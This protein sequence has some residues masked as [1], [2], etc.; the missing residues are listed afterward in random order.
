MPEIPILSD[1]TL[2]GVITF[3]LL[4]TAVDVIGAYLLAASQGKFDLSY[5]AGWLTSHT[6]KRVFPIYAL[7]ALGA[8]IPAAGIPEIPPLFIAATAGVAAYLGETVASIIANFKDA[9]AVKDETSVP[10]TP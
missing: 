3:T 5:V 6:L 1:L 7:A 10:P 4:I 2:L 9:R 8:G